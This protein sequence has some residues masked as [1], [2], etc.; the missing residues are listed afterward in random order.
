MFIADCYN[1]CNNNGICKYEK[2]GEK[3]IYIGRCECFD[4]F[5]GNSCSKSIYIIIIIYIFIG[6]K[7]CPKGAIDINDNPKLE[8]KLPTSGDV[9][10][11]FKH[12]KYEIPSTVSSCND[13]PDKL[14]DKLGGFKGYRNIKYIFYNRKIDCETNDSKFTFTFKYV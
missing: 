10:I 11:T 9:K 1:N 4:G 14:Q 13:L 5:E 3:D 12:V 7:T 6:I 2:I 8:I